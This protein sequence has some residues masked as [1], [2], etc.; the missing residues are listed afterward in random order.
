MSAYEAFALFG[1]PLLMFLTG[2]AAIGIASLPSRKD[3]TPAE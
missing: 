2:L 1:A 3:R